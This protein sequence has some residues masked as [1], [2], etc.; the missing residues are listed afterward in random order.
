MMATAIVLLFLT[1]VAL[2]IA[3]R[4]QGRRIRE[5]E[6]DVI[7]LDDTIDEAAGSYVNLRF[8]YAE[9]VRAHNSLASQFIAEEAHSIH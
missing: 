6:D 4:R 1:Q 5:L 2:L 7:L 3:F 9:L 8:Q